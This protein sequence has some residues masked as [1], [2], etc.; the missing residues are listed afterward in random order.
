MAS[1]AAGRS[2]RRAGEARRGARNGGRRHAQA[3]AALFLPGVKAGARGCWRGASR[4]VSLNTTGHHHDDDA[5]EACVCAAKVTASE[6]S[7]MPSASCW[8][9]CWCWCSWA[10]QAIPHFATRCRTRRRLWTPVVRTSSNGCE[11]QHSVGFADPRERSA[12]FKSGAS[13]SGAG[14]EDSGKRSARCLAV[15]DAGG[16]HPGWAPQPHRIGTS[17]TPSGVEPAARGPRDDELYE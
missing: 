6:A 16:W 3:E 4:D 8:C 17:M 13:L 5:T 11:P 15:A 1:I 7:V 2:V 9:W 10:S 12:R 14:A